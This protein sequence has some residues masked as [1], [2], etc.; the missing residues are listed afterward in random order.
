MFAPNK[1]DP[2]HLEIFQN[3]FQLII[4]TLGGSRYSSNNQGW[5]SYLALTEINGV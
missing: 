1:P 4:K 3:L 5:C 2:I